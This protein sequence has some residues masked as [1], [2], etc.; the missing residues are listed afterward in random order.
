M[1]IAKQ[2]PFENK[3]F[4]AVIVLDKGLLLLDV[5]QIE[6]H[7]SDAS[8]DEFGNTKDANSTTVNASTP[9]V[10]AT[11]YLSDDR[12]NL[13]EATS[14]INIPFS[15]WSWSISTMP[16]RYRFKTDSTNSTLSANLSLN[17]SYGYT[18]GK[19]KFTS[20]LARNRSNTIAIF[21]GAGT[22]DIKASTVKTP[23]KWDRDKTNETADRTNGTIS[24]GIS[25]TRAVNN[26]GL[27]ASLGLD[28]AFGP[29][30]SQWSYQ[31]KP[32]IGLGINA[33]LGIFK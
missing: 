21:F 18:W 4:K 11:L 19:T 12:T 10:G 22:A 15:A 30:S 28:T 29:N 31:N 2:Q 3:P 25:Y 5:W 24:Y 17:A 33:G 9:L 32:W 26:F 7:P 8:K 6:N 14:V 16:F 1:S 13:G 27:V 20:R 23:I